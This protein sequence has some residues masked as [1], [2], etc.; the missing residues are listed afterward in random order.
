MDI[1][2]RDEPVYNSLR[3]WNGNTAQG[4]ISSFRQSVSFVW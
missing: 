2:R 3:S 1:T 4:T